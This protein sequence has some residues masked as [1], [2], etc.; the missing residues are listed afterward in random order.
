MRSLPL[1]SIP[2]FEISITV[3]QAFTPHWLPTNRSARWVTGSVKGHTQLSKSLHCLF[4][5]APERR[6]E[7]YEI[8]SALEADHSWVFFY[9]S[10]KN[11][12][13]ENESIRELWPLSWEERKHTQCTLLWRIDFSIRCRRQNN[14]SWPSRLVKTPDGELITEQPYL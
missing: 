14:K 1:R 12:E 2:L 13:N 7:D 8:Y 11:G 4:F 6:R 3:L 10:L 5:C 9:S